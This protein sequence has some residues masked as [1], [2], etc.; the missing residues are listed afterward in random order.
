[1]AK[2]ICQSCSMPIKKDELKGTEADGSKSQKYCHLCYQKGKFTTPDMTVEQMQEIVRR[3][4]HDEKHW[5]NFMAK[6]AT[7]QIPHLERWK[8]A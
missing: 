8:K 7:K 5:P 3:V 4:L 6:F 2:Q 1:M